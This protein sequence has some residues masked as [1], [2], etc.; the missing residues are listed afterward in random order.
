M[1][2]RDQLC[3]L[4]WTIS[5]WLAYEEERCQ[6]MW[7]ESKYRSTSTG[8]AKKEVEKVDRRRGGK[9]RPCSEAKHQ[10]ERSRA[11]HRYKELSV[12]LQSFQLD[13]DDGEEES[14]LNQSKAKEEVRAIVW[15]LKA[16]SAES[17]KELEVVVAKRRIKSA[18][19]I[20]F[21]Q[22][23]TKGRK[24]SLDSGGEGQVQWGCWHVWLWLVP[25]HALYRWLEDFRSGNLKKEYAHSLQIQVDS[26]RWN[27]QSLDQSSTQGQT[28]TQASLKVV[29]RRAYLIHRYAEEVW[30]I[31]ESPHWWDGPLENVQADQGS[32]RAILPQGHQLSWAPNRRSPYWQFPH[33][34]K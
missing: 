12:S 25:D 5:W 7:E 28:K 8:N 6:S 26:C 16:D 15:I 22:N 4:W 11:S 17:I 29:W 31:M 27:P 10:L 18:S 30:Q 32:L 9:V 1:H 19:R 34:S 23:G 21:Y 2:Y 14:R 33:Q 20:A 3:P 24:A 13:A